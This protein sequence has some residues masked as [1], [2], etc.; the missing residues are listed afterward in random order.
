MANP[1][2]K[3][4]GN[5][6]E[7][8]MKFKEINEAY[9]ILSDPQERA[10]FVLQSYIFLTS[11]GMIATGIKFSEVEMALK[12]ILIRVS[13]YGHIFPDLVSKDLETMKEGS[14]KSMLSYSKT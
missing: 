10:W 5:E 7:A 6:A 13:M 4:I 2:D 11:S 12:E 1:V 3:N 9:E 8:E 14:T